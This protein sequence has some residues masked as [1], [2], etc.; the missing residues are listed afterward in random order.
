MHR[1]FWK[2]FV[3]CIALAG[4]TN[5]CDK[6]REDQTPEEVVEG[7]LDIA[8]NMTAVDQRELLLEY[9]TGNLKS[10]IENATTDQIDKA[11]VQRKYKID[12]YSVVER[13]DRTPRETEITFQLT[14]KDLGLAD[15]SDAASAPRVTTENT[16]SVVRDD[17]VW[18]IRDVLGNRTSIDFPVSEESRITAKAPE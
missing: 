17:G 1:S 6:S 16:V 7:Y 11:Y 4:C 15:N 14:Y 10:A 3:T 8:L 12:T 5:M 13:R 18:L 9:T 2:V